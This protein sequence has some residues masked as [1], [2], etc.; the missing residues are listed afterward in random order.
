MPRSSFFRIGTRCSSRWLLI[1]CAWLSRFGT[2][3]E[4]RSGGDWGRFI[5]HHLFLLPVPLLC[6]RILLPMRLKRHS[7]GDPS[8]PL[9]LHRLRYP[10]MLIASGC[11]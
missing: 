5:L 1:R 3:V 6:S 10:P 7:G 11:W 9:L 8:L 4:K 2:F